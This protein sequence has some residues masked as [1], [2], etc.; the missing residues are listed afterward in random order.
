[1]RHLGF[2]GLVICCASAVPAQAATV[3][4]DL[5]PLIAVAG[6]EVVVAPGQQVEYQLV[7]TVVSDTPVADNLGLEL[8]DL[9]I[10]TGSSIAQLPPEA[11]TP[12]IAEN[13]PMGSSLG[14]VENDRILN[15]GGSQV[16]LGTPFFEGVG[17]G[18]PTILAT[19]RFNTPAVET[20]FTVKVEDDPAA[21][22]AGAGSKEG[23]AVQATGVA[24][25]GFIIR[26][27]STTASGDGTTGTQPD[28]GGGTP[29][30]QPADAGTPAPTD[31]GTST[32]SIIGMAAGGL[33]A[34]AAAFS[35]FGPVGLA[36]GL[37][38]VPVLGILVAMMGS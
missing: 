5:A 20:T 7:V 23:Q 8:F 13:F 18:Q 14:T 16:A 17:V 15:V 10:Q 38:I 34:M 33:L 37:I 19:G 1:M 31:S 21:Y 12:V 32:M 27:S 24:G 35:L 9:N 6:N 30:G 11:F 36:L 4:F 28:A 3:T 29:S 2:A 26:T 22:V 25:P